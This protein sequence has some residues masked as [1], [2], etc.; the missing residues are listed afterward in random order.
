LGTPQRSCNHYRREHA[1]QLKILAKVSK[2]A[3]A[4]PPVGM[5]TLLTAHQ[6]VKC[7][8]KVM[9]LTQHCCHA[10]ITLAL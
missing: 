1:Q 3:A 7:E 9:V 4:A 2:F 5:G 8:N 6:N 10:E